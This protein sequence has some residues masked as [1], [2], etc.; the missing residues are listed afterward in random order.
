MTVKYVTC[1][2]IYKIESDVAEP[3]SEGSENTHLQQGQKCA[4]SNQAV[5]F[6]L[7]YFLVWTALFFEE[8]RFGPNPNPQQLRDLV[9]VLDLSKTTGLAMKCGIQTPSNNI[10]LSKQTLSSLP[11]G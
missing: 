2:N 5:V 6:A 8:S 10:F 11:L 3:V 9:R 7:V 4:I 1:Q